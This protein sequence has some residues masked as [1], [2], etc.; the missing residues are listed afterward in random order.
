M[1]NGKGRRGDEFVKLPNYGGLGAYSA[2]KGN[3]YLC[4]KVG[5]F[6]ERRDGI[7][8]PDGTVFLT[9]GASAGCRVLYTMIAEGSFGVMG[10]IPV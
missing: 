4:K 2:S 8:T 7:P 10:P 5:E 9:N 1:T 6:L 3:G